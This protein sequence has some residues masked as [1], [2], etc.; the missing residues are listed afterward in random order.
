MCLYNT[1][2][3]F[4]FCRHVGD[5]GLRVTDAMI[6]LWFQTEK[7]CLNGAQCELTRMLKMMFQRLIN[8]GL[9]GVE[10]S[11]KDPRFVLF[12]RRQRGT[13]WSV[14]WACLTD[15]WVGVAQQQQQHGQLDAGSMPSSRDEHIDQ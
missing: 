9:H 1:D 5:V 7:F 2:K 3:A 11:F 6:L 4:D 10:L 15:I 8:V 12:L 14:R 13:K